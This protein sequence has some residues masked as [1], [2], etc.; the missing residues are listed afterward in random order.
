MDSTNARVGSEALSVLKSDLTSLSNALH[1][2]YELMQADMRQVNVAWQDSKYQEFVDNYQP[3]IQKCDEIANRYTEWCVKVLDPTIEN[4]IAVETTDVG[5]GGGFVGGGSADAAFVGGAAVAGA[6]AVGVAS[7][8]AGVAGTGGSKIMTDSGSA[9]NSNFNSEESEK[10]KRFHEL[11]PDASPEFAETY[12]KLSPEQQKEYGKEYMRLKNSYDDDMFHVE[13]LRKDVQLR[14]RDSDLG[15]AG[16]AL[17]F[18]A[19]AEKEENAAKKHFREGM[20]K[21]EDSTME[22]AGTKAP[23]PTTKAVPISNGCGSEE[24]PKSFAA[25][26]L[27]RAVDTGLKTVGRPWK[28]VSAEWKAA[29][30]SCDIHDKCYYNGEGKEKCDVDFLMRTP[31]MGMGVIGAKE[32]SAKSYEQAQK[33]RLL[34]EQL[35][36]TWE[37]EH[38][39]TLDAENFRVVPND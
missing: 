38:G 6:A 32:T 17:G 5:D 21:L 36:A 14:G 10:V 23:K 16:G 12:F 27:G 20:H 29:G 1:K 26:T 7:S 22:L 19:Y 37:K 9:A 8:A 39:Q 11:Y 24:D 2:I 25:A 28:S 18:I 13:S 4:V 15:A 34:S 30:E 3:Q 31:I 35:R 33:D